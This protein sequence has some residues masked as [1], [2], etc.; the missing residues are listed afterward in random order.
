MKAPPLVS[1]TEVTNNSLSP[2]S[3]EEFLNGGAVAYIPAGIKN[4]E[5]ASF[6]QDPSLTCKFR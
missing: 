3:Y 2:V 5:L 6:G 1:L 4:L